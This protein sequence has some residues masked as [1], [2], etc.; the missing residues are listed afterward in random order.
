MQLTCVC[1]QSTCK[2]LQKLRRAMIS[3]AGRAADAEL[4]AAVA[5]PRPHVPAPGQRQGVEVAGRQRRHWIRQGYLLRHLRKTG[6]LV[7]R[8]WPLKTMCGS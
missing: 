4:S 7:N 6:G 5:A 3:S 1:R 8:S 2:I